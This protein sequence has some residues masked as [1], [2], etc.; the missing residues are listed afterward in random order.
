MHIDNRFLI[1]MAFLFLGL[2][3]IFG[4]KRF[5]ERLIDLYR[6][7]DIEAPAE[8]YSRQFGFV[9]GLLILLGFLLATGLI[10]IL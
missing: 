4:R 5:S 9:G 7:I 8:Q 1:A 10:D 2:L 3:F 6:R